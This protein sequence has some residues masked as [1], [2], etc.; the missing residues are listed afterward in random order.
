[1]GAGISNIPQ[2]RR[3]VALKML[4]L[5]IGERIEHVKVNGCL[6]GESMEVIVDIVTLH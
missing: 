6:V 2:L 3:Q 1:M 5:I 4:Y